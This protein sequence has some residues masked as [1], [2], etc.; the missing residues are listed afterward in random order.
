M[1]S[2]TCYILIGPPASG[3]STYR[4]ELLTQNPDLVIISS[5]DLI[6]DFARENQMTYSE[7]FHQVDMK[8]VDRMVRERFLRAISEGRDVLVDRTNM[9][10]KSRNRFLSQLPKHYTRV[11]VVFEVPRDVLDARIAARAAA[12]G[13]NIPASVVDHMISTYQEPTASE[14]STVIV[15]AFPRAAA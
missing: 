13:K 11:G 15:R 6:E 14:F 3:K 5:D 1:K 10:V 9:T 12:T 2:P 8:A 7:A 4:E